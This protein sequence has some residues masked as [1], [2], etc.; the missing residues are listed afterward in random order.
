[1]RRRRALRGVRAH[2]A[3]AA[4]RRRDARPRLRRRLLGRLPR[5]GERPARNRAGGPRARRAARA[6]R[7]ARRPGLL[8]RVPRR[9]GALAGLGAGRRGAQR[10]GGG[11]RAGA[12]RRG[13]AV[14]AARRRAA[15]RGV[16]RGAP[17]RRHRAS[18]VSGH[19]Y[20]TGLVWLVATYG[21]LALATAAVLRRHV[22]GLAGAPRAVA[23]AVV[24]TAG[25][26]AAHVVPLALGVLARGTVLATAGV[27]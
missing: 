11:A 10:V 3:R 21:L 2:A 15:R 18:G 25:V 5:P 27:V 23:A 9:R 24:F 17:G 7:A 14:A 26:L 1:A 6:A 19:G 20:A 12:G 16:R 13:R 4:A 22:P 8:G